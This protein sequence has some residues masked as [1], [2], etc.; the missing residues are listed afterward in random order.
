MNKALSITILLLLLSLIHIEVAA[1]DRKI[2]KIN[3][4]ESMVSTIPFSDQYNYPSYKDGTVQ[5]RNGNYAKA[6]MNY[7][8]LF[9]EIQFID[10]KGDTLSA[11]DPGAVQ[12]I[13]PDSSRC[14]FDRNRCALLKPIM[15]APLETA[16]HL[17]L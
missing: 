16:S 8:V 7:N 5:F 3:P 4:G 9:G 11:I 1:Q 13:T 2:L 17:I 14:Y 15:A 6:L 10:P 12:Y